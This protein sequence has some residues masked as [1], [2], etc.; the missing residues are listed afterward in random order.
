MDDPSAIRSLQNAVTQ[1]RIQPGAASNS[2]DWYRQSAQR[3][4]KVHFGNHDVATHKV[5][6]SW[7][8]HADDFERALIDQ[9]K[10]QSVQTGTTD[11]YESHKLLVGPGKSATTTWGG[12]RVAEHF[13]MTWNNRGWQHGGGVSSWICNTCWG[14]AKTEQNKEECHR[15][16]DWSPC[17]DDCTLSRV[18]CE[19][20]GTSMDM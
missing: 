11:A 12:Y 8:V 7:M 6:R 4:G 13:H 14:L 19:A 17:S 20:C 16:R 3:Y 9:A 5:G 10:S 15:C 1:W 2:Y 18:F